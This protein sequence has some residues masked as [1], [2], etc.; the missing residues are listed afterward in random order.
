MIGCAASDGI[1]R[2]KL[3]RCRIIC[4]FCCR[5]LY[6][7][8]KGETGGILRLRQSAS[9]LLGGS[10]VVLVIIRT[11]EIIR[12]LEKSSFWVMNM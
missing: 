4:T 8:I 9:N 12:L 6:E 2:G 11:S 1:V 3:I 7:G 5:E 10:V